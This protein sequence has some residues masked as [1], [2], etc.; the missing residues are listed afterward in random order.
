VV[1]LVF[2]FLISCNRVC[3]LWISSWCV[4]LW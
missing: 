4:Y 2:D 1:S 3:S